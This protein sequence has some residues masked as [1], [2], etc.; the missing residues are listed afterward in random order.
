MV[1]EEEKT[2]EEGVE[3]GEGKEKRGTLDKILG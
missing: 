3:K 1:D 2:A